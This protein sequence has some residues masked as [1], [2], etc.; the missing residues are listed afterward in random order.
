MSGNTGIGERW[1]LRHRG[2]EVASLE[3]TDMDFPWLIASVHASP[4]FDEVR[5]VFD[6][7]VSQM[8]SDDLG[9]AWDAIYTRIRADFELLRPDG[10]SVPEFILHIEGDTASWRWSDEPFAAAD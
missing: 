4:R 7:E 3:V 9:P 8:E 5:G 6:E 10:F 2:E 1:R